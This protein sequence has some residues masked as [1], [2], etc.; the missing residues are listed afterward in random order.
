MNFIV[1]K[2]HLNKD[3]LKKKKHKKQTVT[4]KILDSSSQHPGLLRVYV[5]TKSLGSVQFFVSPWT[6]ARLASL[7][8]EF[9]RQE[10]WSGLPFPPPEDLS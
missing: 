2:L 1:Y 6:V 5:Y 7:S 8:M 3:V 4:T 9:F 10:Y